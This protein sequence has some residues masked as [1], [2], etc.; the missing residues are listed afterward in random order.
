VSDTGLFT[1]FK[2]RGVTMRNRIGVSPMCQYSCVEGMATEWHLVHLGSRAVGGAG[3]VIAEATAVLPEGRISPADLG[4]WSDA[5]ADALARCAAFVEA[6]GAVPGIQLSHAGRKASTAPPW[7]GGRAVDEADGGWSPVMGPSAIPFAAGSPTPAELDAAG[8]ARVVQAFADGARRARDAGFRIVELH[9]AHGYLLHQFLSPLSNRRTDAYGGSFDNRTRL[10]RE[11]VEAVRRE[12]PDALPLW[13]R[14]SGTDWVDGGWDAEQTV[15]L[16]RM[17][18]PLGVDLVDCSSGGLVPGATIPVA[19]GYQV[20]FAERVRR[21]A[22]VATAAVGLIT[23][24]AQA[25]AIVRGGGADVVLLAR[26]LLRDPYWPLH[27]AKA[28]GASITWP[29]QYQRAAD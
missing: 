1:P 16:A 2:Q 9:G 21:D 27:A 26:Q 18:A 25:D 28:L 8:I 12:W 17:V 7:Q 5:H 6:N 24:P 10:V 11:T 20:R 3:A 22:G 4:I 29:V 13:L 19:P 15:E 14:V 23:T